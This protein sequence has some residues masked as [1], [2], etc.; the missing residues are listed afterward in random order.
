MIELRLVVCDR[1]VIDRQLF[2]YDR[3]AVGC[4]DRF[5]VDRQLF[6]GDRVM[7]DR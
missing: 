3:V 4:S 6:V 5:L 7:V 2:V 1:V